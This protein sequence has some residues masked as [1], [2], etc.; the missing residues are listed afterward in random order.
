[1]KKLLLIIATVFLIQTSYAQS[2]IDYFGQTPPG[3]KAVK[4]APGIVSLNKRGEY[5]LTFSTN[6][7]ECYFST[8]SSDYVEKNYRARRTNNSWTSFTETPYF[9]SFFSADGKKIIYEKAGDILMANDT[10]GGWGVPITLQLPINSTSY[11]DSYSETTEGVKYICSNR[12]GGLG[13]QYEIWRINPLTN[14]AENLGSIINCTPRNI[15]PCVA[16]DES[17]LIYTQSNGNYE[18]LYISF[19]KGNAGW[20]VPINMDRSGANINTL[21]QTCPKLSPDGKYLFFNKHNPD[22]ADS[23][24]IYWV[25]TSIIDTLKKIAF[26]TSAVYAPETENLIKVFPNP[27]EGVFTITL[28]SNLAKNAIAEI[29]TMDGKMAL[30]QTIWNKSETIDLAD[31]AKG[32]Y[33][34]KITADSESFTQK[35]SLK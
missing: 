27:S 6:Y 9:A 32:I 30:R 19:N 1:M 15:T 16:R 31:Y 14:Q 21:F 3:N 22:Y 23:S 24:D 7:N 4:F 12:P 34:L 29:F 11:D 17:Y 5:I 2:T 13:K 26:Q 25:S 35:L 18:H 33:I 20:T 28:A 8:Y 10:T